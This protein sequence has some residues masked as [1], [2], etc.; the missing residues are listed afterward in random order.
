MNPSQTHWRWSVDKASE[1][2]RYAKMPGGNIEARTHGDKRQMTEEQGKKPERERVAGGASR[3]L[4]CGQ[5]RARQGQ[6][7]EWRVAVATPRLEVA[8]NKKHHWRTSWKNREHRK[9]EATDTG[10]KSYDW[11]HNQEWMQKWCQQA[12]CAEEMEGNA[13]VLTAAESFLT[14]MLSLSYKWRPFAWI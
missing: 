9:Q 14:P 3:Y 1:I 2:G 10:Q 7:R 5:R 11:Y 6:S 13:P 12:V 8:E 4:Q